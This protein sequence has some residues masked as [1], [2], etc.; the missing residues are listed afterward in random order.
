MPPSNTQIFTFVLF[1]ATLRQLHNTQ[2]GFHR[3]LSFALA[4]HVRTTK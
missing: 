4:Y 2:S 3:I 1:Q